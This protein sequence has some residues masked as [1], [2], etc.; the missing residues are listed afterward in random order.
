M[1]YTLH[2]HVADSYLT[3]IRTSRI[4]TQ[5]E[6]L[7]LHAYIRH[8]PARITIDLL[9]QGGTD[10]NTWLDLDDGMTVDAEIAEF[11]SPNRYLFVSI[12]NQIHIILGHHSWFPQT[13]HFISGAIAI[14]QHMYDHEANDGILP[15]E[16]THMYELTTA[17]MN[18]HLNP[19]ITE[20]IDQEN[21]P[22]S[23]MPPL[24]IYT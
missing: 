23:P 12:I 5:T 20:P 13:S 17:I 15:S 7:C 10:I 24:E 9:L 21:D 6:E 1:P 8:L 14:L 22:N 11:D 16:R 19:V 4:L 3:L 2:N 18:F